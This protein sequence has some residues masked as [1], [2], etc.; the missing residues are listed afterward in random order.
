MNPEALREACAALRQARGAR[1]VVVGDVMVDRYWRGQAG[2]VSPE[3]PVVVVRVEDQQPRAGG[4]ANVAANVAAL[5]LHAVLIGLVGDDRDAEELE[6]ILRDCRV[7]PRLGRVAGARTI[8]KLRVV[9]RQ[10][11]LI[12]LDFEQDFSTADHAILHDT[13]DRELAYGAVVVLSDYAKG[14]LHG[15]PALIAQARKWGRRV[16]VDPKGVDFGKYR[17]ATVITPNLA[18]FVAV[19]GHCPDVAAIEERAR[20]MAR[21][22]QLDAV[23][24]TRGEQGISLVHADRPGL[25]L[26]TMAREVFD[27]T[28]A[29]DTVVATLAA[30]LAAAIP[31]DTAVA[32][33]NEAAGIAVAKF[34]AGTVS[35]DE[36]VVAL[37]DRTPP[38]TT[39]VVTEDELLPAV[40]AR[41]ARGDRVV[42]TNGCFDLL[43]PGHMA[44]LARARELGDC[45]VVAVNDDDSV[46]RL[47]GA[48]RPINPLETRLALLAGLKSVDYAVSFAEDTP[49][50]LIAAVRPDV[51]VKGG[52]YRAEDVAGGDGVTAAGGE[53]RILPFIDGHSSTNLIKRIRGS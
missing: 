5:G 31:L 44:Y 13:F 52:D 50:R 37:Q 4:A 20:N 22:L 12:R 51:L 6:E 49:E 40:S 30:A 24:V 43:H 7:D 41:R 11:Q 47:K 14:T 36:L 34:G 26:P 29:G 32:L 10:Q 46:R 45:L 18:E 48:E 23:L 53:V 28:G 17:G 33:A 42:M 39:G 2:R 19:A 38:S 8:A 1:V 35:T 21:E 3:A 15:A 9:A 27:V 25:H 16:I